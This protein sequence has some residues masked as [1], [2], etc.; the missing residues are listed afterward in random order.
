MVTVAIP[1]VGEP[2]R[3]P[4][5]E[6]LQTVLGNAPELEGAL[7][8]ALEDQGTS[9]GWMRDLGWEINARA[10]EGVSYATWPLPCRL[11]ALQ[12]NEANGQYQSKTDTPDW[13]EFYNDG[14]FDCSLQASSGG[15]TPPGRAS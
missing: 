11:D 15:S 1:R 4:E 6:Q 14:R 7:C 8:A 5:A 13:I 3:E 2:D 9:Y 10:G 12:I